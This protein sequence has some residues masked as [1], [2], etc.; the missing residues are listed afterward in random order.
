MWNLQY[1]QNMNTKPLEE[2]IEGYQ[3]IINNNSNFPTQLS[4]PRISIIDLALTSPDLGPL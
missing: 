2:F 3:L 1:R 4:S